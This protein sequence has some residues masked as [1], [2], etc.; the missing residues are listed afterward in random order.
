MRT[1]VKKDELL[2]DNKVTRFNYYFKSAKHGCKLIVNPSNN[3]FDDTVAPPTSRLS[4]L[5]RI[6]GLFCGIVLLPTFLALFYYG[7]IASDIFISESTFVVRSP[8]QG[9][10]DTSFDSFLK[11]T[12]FSSDLND[13]YTVQS[14]IT[15]RD[16]LKQLENKLKIQQS[17]TQEHVDFFS[18]FPG[19]A[20]WRRGFEDF[21]VYYQN[22]IVSV[23]INP[24]S[25]ILTLQTRAFTADEAVELNRQLISMSEALINQLNERSMQDM[26]S[27]TSREVAMA[28][29]KAKTA[30][31]SLSEYRNKKNVINPEQ[32]STIQLQQISKLQD[33][34]IT[35]QGILTQLQSVT[36]HNPQIPPLKQR[37]AYL[38]KEIKKETDKVAGGEQSLAQKA[39][40][41]ERLALDREFADRQLAST[42]ASLEQARAEALR[43][44]LYLERIS[45]PNT[46]DI[47]MEPQR[48][49][50]VL[51]VFI[52]SFM[53][54]GICSILLAGV[55]EHQN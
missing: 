21:Y 46:P 29:K 15:S 4:F 6:N 32:Q 49:R 13:S 27:Y 42:L 1:K 5:R 51:A 24:A 30:A 40:D 22:N 16:A 20:W 47:A 9:A 19:P 44:Q 31:I 43:K 14:F 26:M 18:R 23:Q 52:I 50:G 28:E 36:S 34:L 53:V 17:F 11:S 7:C 25:S 2:D 38:K 3:S 54:Y 10:L 39:A 45:Q 8:E 55:R 12:G 41:Y 48:M 35:T 33:E 37:V